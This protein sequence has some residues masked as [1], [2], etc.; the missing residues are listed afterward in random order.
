MSISK[1][2]ITI[3]AFIFS[4]FVLVGTQNSNLSQIL[5]G[6][7]FPNVVIVCCY[8][9]NFYPSIHPFI[10]IQFA[11]C[12]ARSWLFPFKSIMIPGITEKKYCYNTV[13]PKCTCIVDAY[14]QFSQRACTNFMQTH[15]YLLIST[16]FFILTTNQHRSLHSQNKQVWVRS[17]IRWQSL[18][19]FAQ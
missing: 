15:L 7:K 16:H 19:F 17:K 1:V 8:A 6:Q 4:E 3:T 18:G 11:D 14:C 5:F 12:F 10:E 2:N 13:S 9:C